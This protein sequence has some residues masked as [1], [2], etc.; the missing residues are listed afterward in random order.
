MHVLQGDIS[1]IGEKVSNKI[2]NTGI[3]PSGRVSGVVKGGLGGT[4][5]GELD[6]TNKR[7]LGGANIEVGKKADVGTITSTNN[8]PNDGSKVTD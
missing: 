6:R 8:R 4:N 2:N 5:K 1:C 3:S 7:M